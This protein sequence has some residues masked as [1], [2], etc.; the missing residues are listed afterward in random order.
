MLSFCT[1][2]HN[3]S[4]IFQCLTFSVQE[5]LFTTRL[6]ASAVIK[7][8]NAFFSLPITAE[9]GKKILSFL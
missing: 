5:I 2:R 7:M 4:D 1:E 8:R 9:G 6:R 3:M